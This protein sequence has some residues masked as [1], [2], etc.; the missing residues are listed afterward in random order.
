MLAIAT[1]TFAESQ[2]SSFRI[3][4]EASFCLTTLM[5]SPEKKPLVVNDPLLWL[6]GPRI[7]V[8]SDNAWSQSI[9]TNIRD[10]SLISNKQ[11]IFASHFR[12]RDLSKLLE[13]QSM[14]I[15]A[16]SLLV[17]DCQPKASIPEHSL[18]VGDHSKGFD[19]TLAA[20]LDHV[21]KVWYI[22]SRQRQG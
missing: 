12:R 16:Q 6:L 8:P 1:V 7:T 20:S 14:T 17:V 15:S 18:S 11:K 10:S 2:R 5:R 21:S 9:F 13:D 19:T 22:L 3:E 4:D